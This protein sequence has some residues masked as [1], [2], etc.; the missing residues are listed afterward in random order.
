MEYGVISILPAFV[1]IVIAL[2]TRHTFEALIVGTFSAYVIVAGPG[3]LNAWLDTLFEV[4]TDY[5][6]QW[7]IMVCGLFGSLIALLSACHGTFAF[8]E[9]IAKVCKSGRSSLV[10]TWIMGILI[11]IDDYLNIITL[12]TCMCP[13]TDRYKEPREATAYIIDST[14][15]PVC[16]L[17]PISTWAIFYTSIFYAQ[18][19]TAALGYADGFSMYIHLIPYTFYPLFTLLVVLLFCLKLLPRLGRMKKAYERV[20]QGGPLLTKKETD[21][22][23]EIMEKEDMGKP[24]KKGN[25]WDF[26]IPILLVIIL[27]VICGEMMVG[28]IVAIVVCMVMYL[29]RRL[30]TFERFCSVFMEGFCNMIPTLAV[31]VAAFIMQHAADEI[32]LPAFVISVVRPFMNAALFPAIVFVV[33]ALLTFVTGS[34]WGIPAVCVPIIVPLAAAVDANMLLTLAA[35]LSAGTFGSHA[36]F[37]SDATLL[38]SASCGIDNMDHALSQFPYAMIGA[39][40]S[41]VAFL[42]CGLAGI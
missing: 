12:G 9:K 37:Y 16:V 8:T 13:V 21:R 22:A 33:V 23:D 1:V 41:F 30:L 11:F 20:G 14:G 24:D 29:P 6:V 3:F 15:A 28:L 39:V 26:L 10:V 5:D 25:V 34:N 31:V 40:L 42:V 38:T 36:C 18:P 4:L 35:I 32:G 17:L 2:T 19:E 27:T 7:V